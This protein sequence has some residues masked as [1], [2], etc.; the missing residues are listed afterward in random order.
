[1]VSL[2]VCPYIGI[3]ACAVVLVTYFNPFCCVAYRQDHNTLELYL[4]EP[5]GSPVIR[6]PHVILLPVVMLS[7]AMVLPICYTTE[8]W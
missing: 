4:I 3:V 2:Y 8:W 6:V 1:M 7:I 5:G